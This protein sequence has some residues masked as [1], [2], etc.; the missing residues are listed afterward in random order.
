MTAQPM[1]TSLA[2]VRKLLPLRIRSITPSHKRIDLL[3]D[4]GRIFCSVP[5]YDDDIAAARAHAE[6]IRDAM[7]GME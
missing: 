5:V 7:N 4:G 1:S 3:T 2:K 6:L